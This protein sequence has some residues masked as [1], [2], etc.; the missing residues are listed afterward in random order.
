MD[1]F[2]PYFDQYLLKLKR[3]SLFKTYGFFVKP[4][5]IQN[6]VGLIL[7]GKF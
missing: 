6:T 4:V 2:V 5:T 3:T 7:L 1:S